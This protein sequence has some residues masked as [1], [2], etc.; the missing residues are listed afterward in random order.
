MA[1]ILKV[2]NFTELMQ[3]ESRLTCHK[4]RHALKTKLCNE[5]FSIFCF[6]VIIKIIKL[7]G[8]HKTSMPKFCFLFGL[9]RFNVHQERSLYSQA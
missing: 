2:G 9:N 5:I 4:V 1:L 3:G 6:K 7:Q 8:V